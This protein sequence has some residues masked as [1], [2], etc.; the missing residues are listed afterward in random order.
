V[1]LHN[2]PQVYSGFQTED[3]MPDAGDL[4]STF[5]TRVGNRMTDREMVHDLSLL[6]V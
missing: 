3:Y 5:Q 4:V 2:F 1:L 6:G